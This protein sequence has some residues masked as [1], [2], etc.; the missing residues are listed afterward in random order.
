MFNYFVFEKPVFVAYEDFGE[1]LCNKFVDRLLVLELKEAHE[2][3]GGEEFILA[4]KG[5]GGF[6]CVFSSGARHLLRS[7]VI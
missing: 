2:L 4:K 3:L 5:A 1:T 6:E 7:L